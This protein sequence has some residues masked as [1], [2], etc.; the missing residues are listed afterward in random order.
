MGTHRDQ[1]SL[2]NLQ[3]LDVFLGFTEKIYNLDLYSETA[4]KLEKFGFHC[5]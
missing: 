3:S 5:V 1:E 4:Q 2:G